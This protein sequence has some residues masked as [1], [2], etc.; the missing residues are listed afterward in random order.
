[1]PQGA[2]I[3]PNGVPDPTM[4]QP[5][6]IE[7]VEAVGAST[8]FAL[9]FD[10]HIEEG[11]LPLLRE[12]RLGPEAEIVVRVPDGDVTA[13]LVRGPVTRQRISLVTAGAGSSLE[14]I[15]ADATVTLAREHKV[16][17]WPSTSDS[18]AILEVLS[19]AG[20]VPQVT[21]PTS[22]VHTELK[23]ALVQ[24]ET[25]LHLIRRLARR[26]GCWFWL[27]YEPISAMATA[28]VARP[29]VNDPTGIHFHL[30]SSKRN[31]E[32]AT[33]EWDAERVVST[34]ALHR[35]VFGG[36][37]FDG[38][39]KRSPLSGLA[40]RALGDIL[41]QPR[42][43]QLSLPVDDAGDL[44]ARSE[45][46]LIDDGWFV[47]VTLTTRVRDLRR[48]VRAHSVAELHDAGSRHSG[49]YLVSRVTH[50]IHDADHWMDVEL[51][52]NGWNGG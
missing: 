51:V 31:I 11:D 28:H 38:S 13:V 10:F 49:K 19:G 20:W 45:G 50:R 6:R 21:L 52:R 47:Q 15:G 9:S 8:T 42:Q 18:A 7:I 40:D 1:M 5:S 14:V 29:P 36:S 17:V 41:S 46:A 32:T 12:S 48:V 23:N 22:V 30:D 37:D 26:N 33:I 44:I 43:A 24:R 16:R 34:K 3:L 2:E 39:V 35:D 27:S 4:P 25:D